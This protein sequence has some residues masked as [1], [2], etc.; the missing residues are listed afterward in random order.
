[1][2]FSAKFDYSATGKRSGSWMPRGAFFNRKKW[3]EYLISKGLNKCSRCGYD[4]CFG[5]IDFHHIDPKQKLF[6]M[7]SCFSR[8]ISWDAL[9]ELEKTIPLC[10]NCH[11]EVHANKL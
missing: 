3:K 10:A 9:Q 11:R 1:M 8:P 4:K 6:V 5:A 7:S 2:D